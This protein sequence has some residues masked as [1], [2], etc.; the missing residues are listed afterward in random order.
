MIMRRKTGKRVRLLKRID[1]R[2]DGACKAYGGASSQLCRGDR[3]ESNESSRRCLSVYSYVT[4]RK[5]GFVPRAHEFR[6]GNFISTNSNFFALHSTSSFWRASCLLPEWLLVSSCI[7]GGILVLSVQAVPGDDGAALNSRDRW[8][9]VPHWSGCQQADQYIP[10][11]ARFTALR[12][13]P[14]LVTRSE[15]RGVS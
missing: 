9:V 4:G 10:L 3:S 6:P 8:P 15:P 11:S 1:E 2:V 13:P 12:R 5:R 7:H 14:L